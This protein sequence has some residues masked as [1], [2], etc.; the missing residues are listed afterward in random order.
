[1]ET[2]L[3]CRRLACAWAAVLG[4][5]LC[6][7]APAA[8]APDESVD[9]R[10]LAP[11]LRARDTLAL[12][13]RLADLEATGARTREGWL[14]LPRH[15][16]ALGVAAAD[17]P[18]LAAALDSWSARSPA[19]W[20]A[21]MADGWRH[22]MQHHDP[23]A[24]DR[25][26]DA[27][28]VPGQ[29]DGRLRALARAAFERARE[30]APRSP[31]P[32]AALLSLQVIERAPLGDRWQTLASACNR[33]RVCESARVVMLT[34]L[35]PHLGGSVE[36]LLA[37][38]HASA[39]SHPD[40]P[41]LGLLVALAHRKIGLAFGRPDQ[42]FHEPGV[43]EEVDRA[44]ARHLAAHPEALRHRNEYV[45][46]AC[47]AGRAETARREFE[48]IGDGFLA[49]AWKGDFREFSKR[50]A[51]AFEAARSEARAQLAP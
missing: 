41:R 48:R 34:G 19:S 14:A 3:R 26:L 17:D 33:D 25:S 32:D 31:E 49:A 45:R 2:R 39:E 11:L 1:M 9:P 37:F 30:L 29:P 51:W 20:M 15:L 8:G 12:E 13:T 50:R 7:S 21:Q 6:V 22:V 38:A 46:V 18:D 23:R 43:F 28:E 47:W 27:A 24:D 36:A 4:A 44:Y 5:V 10:T 42:H 35:E 16:F 40:D